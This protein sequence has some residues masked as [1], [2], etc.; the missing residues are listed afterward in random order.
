LRCVPATPKLEGVV[1]PSLRMAEVHLRL[2]S[3]LGELN[4]LKI[5]GRGFLPSRLQRRCARF[6]SR[7]KNP[8]DLPRDPSGVPPWVPTAVIKPSSGFIH[9]DLI[10]CRGGFGTLK[11]QRGR[12][13]LSEAKMGEATRGGDGAGRWNLGSSQNCWDVSKIHFS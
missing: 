5:A 10:P 2:I 9:P 11:Q 1:K 8:A 4:S 3:Y 13:G 6:S 7:Y 12:E